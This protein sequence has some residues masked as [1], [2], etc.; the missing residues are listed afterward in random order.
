MNV[1]TTRRCLLAACLA[2]ATLP[3]GVAA[4]GPP[5]LLFAPERP[6]D[7]EIVRVTV[8][9][10]SGVT[11]CAPTF[12]ASVDE[13]ASRVRLLGTS[14]DPPPSSDPPIP[15]PGPW[16]T[17]QVVIGHLRPGL[18]K[19]EATLNDE[20]YASASLTV[21]PSPTRVVIGSFEYFGTNFRIEV[22][23]RDP[24]T[25]ELRLAPGVALSDHAAQ[26]WFFA[27]GNPELTVKILDGRA[28]NGHHWLFASSLTNVELTLRV[29]GCVEGDPPFC[30]PLEDHHVPA[31]R[32]FDIVDLTAF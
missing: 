4:A 5:L 25:G 28:V 31:G 6:T 3:A 11:P 20:P 18:W 19:V 26:F 24:R 23:W 32:T 12:F 30:L 10:E 27:P 2:L 7:S 8:L 1:P 21:V 14:H 17:S 15:C 9:G 13:T 29:T 16:W 22:E